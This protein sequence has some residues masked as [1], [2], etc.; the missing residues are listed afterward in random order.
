MV[1]C[2]MTHIMNHV[3][4]HLV[5]LERASRSLNFLHLLTY[6]DYDNA[7]FIS[8]YR[9]VEVKRRYWAG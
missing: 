5:G 8:V 9:N 7:T 2:D 4:A 6:Y 3:H 1:A